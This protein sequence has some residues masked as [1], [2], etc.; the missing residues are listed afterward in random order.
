MLLC[1][2]SEGHDFSTILTLPP[3]EPFSRLRSIRDCEEPS[4]W[5]TYWQHDTL[6]QKP[7]SRCSSKERVV[8]R[9]LREVELGAARRLSHARLHNLIDRHFVIL[10][11]EFGIRMRAVQRC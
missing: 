7:I 10:A 4:L 6:C 3:A 5:S 1:G 8:N 2:E 9:N 11:L